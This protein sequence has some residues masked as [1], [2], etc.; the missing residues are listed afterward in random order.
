M[1]VYRDPLQYA[2]YVRLRAAATTE[3]SI[4]PDQKRGFAICARMNRT[5]AVKACK[6]EYLMQHNIEEN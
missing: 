2:N 5:V 1:R 6:I 4:K 3:N